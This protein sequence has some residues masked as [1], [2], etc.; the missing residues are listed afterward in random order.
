MPTM[1]APNS[2][3]R[4]CRGTGRAGVGRAAARL[5]RPALHRYRRVRRHRQAQDVVRASAALIVADRASPAS[6]CAA[7]PSA[8]T[9]RAAP[10][11][12]CPPQ[13]RTGQVTTQQVE[14]VFTKTL[15]KAPESVVAVG[16]GGSATVQI[17]SETLS[18][19]GDREAAHRAVRRVPAQGRRRSAQQA[20]DQRLRRCRRRG[21][22]RSPRRRSS[23]WWCSW[24]SSR[25][26]SPCATS[27]TWR[28]RRWRR[29][30]STSSVTGGRLL[31]GRVRGHPGHGDRPADD[32]RLLALRHRHR[33]RQ[34]RG[35]HPRFR[36]HHPAYVR[37]TGQPGD[38]PDV[39]AV[40][41]H[42]PD[43]GAA[44][45]RADRGRGVAA[46]RRDAARTWRWCS[47]SASS[48]APTRR[49]SSPRRCW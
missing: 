20:G 26:T 16:N 9:S 27:G 35:E 32:S 24:C 13:V 46:R 19:A 33:V 36:A 17:R 18:N 40:D 21:A 7:S 2:T 3:H 39:H 22:G 43:L 6:C 4:D 8:S 31:A 37:R 44:D 11:C 30:C 28:S 5:L 25:S 42:Q 34:G 48:S 47:W 23:R 12:R 1:P 49:S 15:G 45:P 10:R 41:Q 29:W 14:D 38:Q